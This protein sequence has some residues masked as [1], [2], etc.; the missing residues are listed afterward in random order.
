MP[1][2]SFLL[3]V[4]CLAV[5]VLANC[6]TGQVRSA[7]ISELQ[8]PQNNV[9][10]LPYRLGPG[11]QITVDAVDAEELANRTFRISTDGFL[12]LPLAGRLSAGGLTVPQL[13]T[14]VCKRLSKYI[15]DP[16]VNI[17]VVELRSMP[18]S[19]LGAVSSPGVH[20]LQSETTLTEA[21]SQAGGFAKDAGYSVRIT[22][23]QQW[24]PLPLPNAKTDVTGQYSVAE[25]NIKDLIEAT[26]PGDNIL[27]RPND[28][29]TVPKAKLI[30][31]LG[32]V[33]RSGG[34][35]LSEGNSV[36]AI[37]ALA[38]AE[39]LNSTA[40]PRNA[41]ILKFQ[42]GTNARKEVPINLKNILSG[43]SSDVTLEANDVLFIPDNTAKRAGVKIAE[44]AMQTISGVIIWRGL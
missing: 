7:E 36:S 33:H 42:N 14:E 28:V 38:L 20:Q 15:R 18:V 32:E 35:A 25:V 3:K 10:A 27:V 12:D 43:K 24:G 2:L 19:V 44:S 6:A 22:R 5:T 1:Q 8:R 17:N 13:E 11:D 16:I 9:K 41:R 40:A 37:Q 23:Q 26:N 34:F 29:I 21:I 31:V 30:Y 4:T 39:G